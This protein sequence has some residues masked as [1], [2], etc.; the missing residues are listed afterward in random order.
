MTLLEHF[1]RPAVENEEVQ[2][3]LVKFCELGF[4]REVFGM[5][6]QRG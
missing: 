3:G 2:A 6:V 1:S 5:Q 4:E